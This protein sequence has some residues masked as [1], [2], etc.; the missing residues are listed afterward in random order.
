MAD[1][2]INSISSISS[3]SGGH[4]KDLLSSSSLSSLSKIIVKPSDKVAAAAAT[5]AAANDLAIDMNK[6]KQLVKQESDLKSQYNS[7]QKDLH[8]QRVKNLREVS[9]KLK[10][11][12]WKY[13]TVE[14]LLGL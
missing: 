1:L 11:D 4:H 7:L 12:V 14:S 5:T 8:L 6:L 13:P 2:N 10:E 9:D 3:S